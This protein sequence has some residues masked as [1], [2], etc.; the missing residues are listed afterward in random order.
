MT[1]LRWIQS[2][3]AYGKDGK[4]TIT[5]DGHTHRWVVSSELEDGS[6]LSSRTT[7]AEAM[8]WC[9]NKECDE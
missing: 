5:F 9:E 4:Y 6:W 3:I 1:S 7:L 2:L 8:E